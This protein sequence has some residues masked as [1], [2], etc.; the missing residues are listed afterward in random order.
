MLDEQI[1]EAIELL[2][3]ALFEK[4][5]VDR[6]ECKG[7]GNNENWEGYYPNGPKQWF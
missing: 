7:Y 4:E 2:K 1:S 5:L 3:T 6:H